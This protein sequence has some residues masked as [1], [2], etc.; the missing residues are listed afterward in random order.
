MI[1]RIFLFSPLLEEKLVIESLRTSAIARDQ[2]STLDQLNQAKHSLS[3]TEDRSNRVHKRVN[4]E[5]NDIEN[6]LD[7]AR[8]VL[9]TSE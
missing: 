2:Q 1:G 3:Q 4:R 9:I 8:T 5:R 6:T 7:E